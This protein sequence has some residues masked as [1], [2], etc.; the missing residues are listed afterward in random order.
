M[1]CNETL[2]QIWKA[3]HACNTPDLV[4]ELDERSRVV[5]VD[6]V[7]WPGLDQHPAL[8]LAAAEHHCAGDDGVR[9]D[10]TFL[11]DRH[12][13][14]SCGA[15]SALRRVSLHDRRLAGSE[16]QYV[17]FAPGA[18]WEMVSISMNA[19]CQGRRGFVSMTYTFQSPFF[20][21]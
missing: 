19:A 11:R 18:G 21:G 10:S 3:G 13:L 16:D 5:R 9:D 14:F 4:P 12:D 6:G 8:V 1:A 15:M 2:S 7:L 17:I 20:V